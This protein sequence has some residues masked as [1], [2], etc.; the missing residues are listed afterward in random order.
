[1]FQ[2]IGPSSSC[3]ANIRSPTICFMASAS[4]QKTS[5]FKKYIEHVY[6]NA[7]TVIVGHRAARVSIPVGSVLIVLT[8]LG[9]AHPLAQVCLLRL[10]AASKYAYPGNSEHCL[11]TALMI[12]RSTLHWRY[13]CVASCC[14]IVRAT[15]TI[16][17][18]PTHGLCS[19]SSLTQ[20]RFAQCRQKNVLGTSPL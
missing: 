17:L 1:M 2:R 12:Y 5:A 15:I 18:R 8:P 7:C 11:R 20:G 19:P 10:F 3:P 9:T 14:W 4:L 13:S 6:K 16:R